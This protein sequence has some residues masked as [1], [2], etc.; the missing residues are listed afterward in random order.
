MIKDKMFKEFLTR[1]EC[2]LKWNHLWVYLS[3]DLLWIRWGI[4][5][6]GFALK[7]T[8]L[9]FSERYGNTKLIK[10][11]FGWR[12]QFLEQFNSNQIA[13]IARNQMH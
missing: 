1:K 4:A 11:P 10:L 7:R 2:K 6:K 3:T 13:K 8:K 5:K 12:F 9:I